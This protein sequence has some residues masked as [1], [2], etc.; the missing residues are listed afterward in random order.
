MRSFLRL[1]NSVFTLE[2]H[3]G[4]L[5]F[6]LLGMLTPPKEGQT[7]PRGTPVNPLLNIPGPLGEVFRLFSMSSTCE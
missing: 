6:G 2:N 1:K 4:D 5:L 3:P 7:C